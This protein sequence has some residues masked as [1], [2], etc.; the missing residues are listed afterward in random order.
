VTSVVL[1]EYTIEKLIVNGTLEIYYS[2][3]NIPIG[4]SSYP[5]QFPVSTCT[6]M[7]CGS[8]TI[9]DVDTNMTYSI[10]STHG[11]SVL[12]GESYAILCPGYLS[13]NATSSFSLVLSLRKIQTCV[14]TPSLGS[15]T[16]Q[17]L[18]GQLFTVAIGALPDGCYY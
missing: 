9:S 17:Q 4:S 11:G 2:S 15:K 18:S 10:I 5:S 1:A 3:V 13:F 7:N 14:I 16:S 6:N 8:S 12:M